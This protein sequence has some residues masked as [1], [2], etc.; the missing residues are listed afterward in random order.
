MVLF[1][2]P[3][4]GRDT[5]DPSQRRV[6]L[7]GNVL[8]RRGRRPNPDA[9]QRPCREAARLVLPSA[10]LVLSLYPAAGRA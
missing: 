1:W 5:A 9:L 7:L 2:A 3:A 4:P 8:A 6:P 10:Y